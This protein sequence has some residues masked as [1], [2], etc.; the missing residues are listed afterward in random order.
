MTQ[1]ARIEVRA[2]K[3]VKSIIQKA[4]KINGLTLTDFVLNASYCCAVE[5]IKNHKE[6]IAAL[7][8]MK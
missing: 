3:K 5:I 6:V 1:T 2:E 8:E 4:A 7:K